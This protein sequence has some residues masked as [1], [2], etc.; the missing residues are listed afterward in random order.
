MLRSRLAVRCR[1]AFASLLLL[2]PLRLAAQRRTPEFTRQLILVPNFGVVDSAGS[3]S[4]SKADMRLGRKVADAVRDRLAGLLNKRE[5]HVISGYDIRQSLAK[6]GIWPDTVLSTPDLH[7]Q[8]AQ[9][10]ADE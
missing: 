10:R 7:R 1:P 6:S 4:L 3:P 9:L 8:G 2:A 5:A